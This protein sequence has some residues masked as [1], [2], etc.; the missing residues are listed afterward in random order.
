M[1]K[2]P[3][4]WGWPQTRYSPV[5]YACPHGVGHGQH[6][7]GCDGCCS[8]ESF[9]RRCLIANS[10]WVGLVADFMR[11]SGQRKMQKDDLVNL[12]GCLVGEEYSE[13]NYALTPESTLDACVDLIW[14]LL[15]F[16]LSKGY[17]I[18]GAFREVARSNLEKVVGK[19]K[20]SS[21]GKILKPKGWKPPNLTPYLEE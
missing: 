10:S 13:W 11:M 15:G 18:D 16:M 3:T 21:N 5:E 4:T 14:V 19:V 2:C 6:V 1:K 20:R 8:S 12:Y 9:S 17:D 7:H